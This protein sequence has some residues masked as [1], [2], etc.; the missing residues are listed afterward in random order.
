MALDYKTL[1][2]EYLGGPSLAP[3]GV[4][5]RDDGNGNNIVTLVHSIPLINYNIPF[6]RTMGYNGPDNVEVAGQGDNA[7]ETYI[8]PQFADWFATTNLTIGASWPVDSYVYWTFF[9]NSVPVGKCLRV[10]ENT[11]FIEMMGPVLMAFA[12]PVAAMWSIGGQVAA[13]IADDPRLTAVAKIGQ[14]VTGNVD[15]NALSTETVTVGDTAMFDD[16]SWDSFDYSDGESFT[17]FSDAENVSFGFDTMGDD[18]DWAS[19]ADDA[20]TL[21]IGDNYNDMV[22]DYGTT[23]ESAV[24]DYGTIVDDT[25]FTAEEW[26]KYQE[27]LKIAQQINKVVNPVDTRA[28]NT[29]GGTKYS[30]TAASVAKALAESTAKSQ[31]SAPSI[32]DQALGVM[33]QIETALPR[34]YTGQLGTNKAGV[35][36]QSNMT[37][38][39]IGGALVLVALYMHSKG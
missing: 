31:G 20:E 9:Q 4:Q 3:G 1:Y 8:N 30:Q 34:S 12:G 6:L 32:L 33:K 24:S 13:G 15:A 39:Y 2:W 18:F 10:I 26:N 29:G 19:M 14:V 36:Q 11:T 22:Q 35:A 28:T 27:G 16:F 7:G 38:I 23:A 37:L 21:D 5:G 25:G 17:A